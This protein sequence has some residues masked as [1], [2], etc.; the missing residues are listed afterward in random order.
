[1]R[2]AKDATSQM[3]IVG[4]ASDMPVTGISSLVRPFRAVTSQASAFSRQN[5]TA[6]DRTS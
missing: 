6:N 4:L 3:P 2:V 5:S 1:M